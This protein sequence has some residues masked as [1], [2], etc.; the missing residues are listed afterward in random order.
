VLAI[1]STSALFVASQRLLPLEYVSLGQPKLT[2]RV[3]QFAAL[4]TAF[5]LL[6]GTTV[7]WLAG[8]Y[9]FAL[10]KRGDAGSQGRPTRALRT[11]VTAGQASFAMFLLAVAALVGRSYANL[12]TQDT[13]F[14]SGDGIVLST[15]YPPDH[16]GVRLQDDIDLA[17][18]RLRRQ[19]GVRS[20]GA[21]VGSMLDR[22][23]IAGGLEVDG[24]LVTCMTKRVTPSYFSAVGSSFVA[25]RQLL[26]HGEIVV[27]DSFARLAWPNIS[28]IG[29]RAGSGGQFEVVGVIRDEFNFALDVSP[30]PTVFSILEN[31]WA[32][33]IGTLCGQVSYVVGLDGTARDV[34]SLLTRAILEVNRDAVVFETANIRQRLFATIKDRS[35]AT[36]V[37]GL[38]AL[39][40][41]AVCLAGVVTV[42]GFILARRTREIAVHLALGARPAQLLRLLLTEALASLAVGIAAGLLTARW[43]SALLRHLLYGIQPG[44][45]PT[46][47]AAAGLMAGAAIATAFWPVRRALQASPATALRVE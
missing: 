30:E 2:W 1:G 39:I 32:D 20:A 43:A 4:T 6:A 33:C 29:R 14:S 45:W 25:G 28:V 16:V 31:P 26:S 5:V 17:I 23:L 42:L 36:L 44:D 18:E 3:G 8:R 7:A 46:I 27:T 24:R 47:L 15:S 10:L 21:A 9:T 34:R 13:G 40:A 22:L 41:V 12:L 35:F 37:L 11:V 19:P 38:F